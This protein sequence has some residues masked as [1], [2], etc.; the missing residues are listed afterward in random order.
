MIFESFIRNFFKVCF[1]NLGILASLF[2]AN[3]EQF[4]PYLRA[5]VEFKKYTL[6][7][8]GGRGLKKAFGSAKRDD[9]N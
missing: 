9:G 5:K 2:V 1:R 8:V 6:T 3:K 4:P 7:N